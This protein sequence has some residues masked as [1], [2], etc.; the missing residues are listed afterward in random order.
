MNTPSQITSL[1]I[2]E[3]LAGATTK[4]T[5]EINLNF[6]PD[7]IQVAHVYYEPTLADTKMHQISSDLINTEDNVLQTI[8]A[9]VHY[10]TPLIFSNNKQIRGTYDF[11]ISEG[12]LG[13]GVFSMSLTFIK[14]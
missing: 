3:N 8:Y 12:G 4:I 7:I 11:N 6:I 1:I 10:A 9:E 2:S 13:A 5:K 14:Y